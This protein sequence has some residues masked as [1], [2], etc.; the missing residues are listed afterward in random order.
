MRDGTAAPPA[1]YIRFAK[2]GLNWIKPSWKILKGPRMILITLIKLALPAQKKSVF[3]LLIKKTD[4]YRT[5]NRSI[6]D[7]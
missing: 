3:L 4:D 5:F 1:L 6:E 7:Y 2:T